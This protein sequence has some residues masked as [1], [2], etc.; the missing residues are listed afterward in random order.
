L[1]IALIRF[2]TLLFR[3]IS[4]PLNCCVFVALALYALW[5]NWV[6]KILLESFRPAINDYKRH[7][8]PR[9]ACGEF[10]IYQLGASARAAFDGGNY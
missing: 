10:A 3:D 9:F 5:P 6:V 1:F 2:I 7:Y 8:G 4:F